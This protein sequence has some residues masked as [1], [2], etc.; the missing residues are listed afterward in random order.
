M[1]H[2]EYLKK[3]KRKK[4]KKVWLFLLLFFLAGAGILY[5]Q[6]QKAQAEQTDPNARENVVLAEGQSWLELR[7]ESITGNEIRTSEGDSYL[8]PVGTEVVT[9][10][11][12]VTTFSRLA[13]GDRIFCLVQE[14]NGEKVIL[15]IWVEEQR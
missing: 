15:K 1:E 2:T 11:G 12:S 3:K 10:L 8:I 5:G 13:S 6:K 14:E 9:K 4:R 7:I